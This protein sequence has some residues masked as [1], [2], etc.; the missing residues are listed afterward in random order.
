MKIILLFTFVASF[1]VY[2]QELYVKSLLAN[3]L[4]APAGSSKKIAVLKRGEKISVIEKKDTWVRIRNDKISGWLQVVLLSET[5]PQKRV[6]LLESDVDIS[7]SARKRASGFTSTAAARGL[8]ESGRKRI[9]LMQRPDYDA[10]ERMEKTKAD[11]TRSV[12]FVN[13]EV[14]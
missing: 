14:E 2:A 3:V 5:E 10:L 9:G 6:S 7:T 4:S 13:M 11:E 1:S 8:A 12:E